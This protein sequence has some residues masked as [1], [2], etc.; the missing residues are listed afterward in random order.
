MHE[1]NDGG[2]LQPDC[3]REHGLLLHNHVWV[4]NREH[5]CDHVPFVLVFPIALSLV[6]GN[7]VSLEFPNGTAN[8]FS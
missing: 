6:D 7:A 1:Y 2:E 5:I 4:R 8:G 3:E